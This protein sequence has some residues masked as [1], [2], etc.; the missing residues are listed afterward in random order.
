MVEEGKSVDE[1]EDHQGMS[2]VDDGDDDRSEV[3]D[4][5]GSEVVSE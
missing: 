5:D 2:D 4:V 3:M 1:D